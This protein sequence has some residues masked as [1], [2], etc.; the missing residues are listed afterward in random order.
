MSHDPIAILVVNTG[1]KFARVYYTLCEEEFCFTLKPR[2]NRLINA[3]AEYIE[4]EYG[5][6]ITMDIR[7]PAALGLE[8]VGQSNLQDC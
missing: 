8:M 6:I 1:K 2:Q 4:A 5:E 7:N 3:Q